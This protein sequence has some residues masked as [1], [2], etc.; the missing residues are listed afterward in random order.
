MEIKRQPATPG[1]WYVG[2]EGTNSGRLDAEIDQF[3]FQ[4]PNG[5]HMQNIYDFLGQPMKFRCP[6]GRVRKRP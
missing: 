1:V 2:I 5:R 6:S 4:L 3:G